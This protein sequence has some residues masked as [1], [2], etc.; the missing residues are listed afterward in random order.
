MIKLWYYPAVITALLISGLLLTFQDYNLNLN[1]MD[2]NRTISCFK[3]YSEDEKII[4]SSSF[5]NELLQYDNLDIIK[6]EGGEKGENTAVVEIKG[7]LNKAGDML[8]KISS[9]DGIKTIS[10]INVSVE[11]NMTKISAVINYLPNIICK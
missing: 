7:N 9:L 6:I 3:A 8:N 11:N 4:S 5:V 2:L 1:I 10:N